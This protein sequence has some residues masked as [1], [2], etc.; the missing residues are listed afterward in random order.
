M[1]KEITANGWY[2]KRLNAIFHALIA[3]GFKIV[4]TYEIAKKAWD[5][6][7]LTHEENAIVKRSKLLILR[8][9]LKT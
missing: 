3:N 6:L 2:S 5:I 7:E 1:N 9:K 4:Q 8:M